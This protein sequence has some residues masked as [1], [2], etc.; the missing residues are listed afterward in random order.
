[1]LY[2]MMGLIVGVV[3]LG[4]AWLSRARG[5]RLTWYEWLFAGA[6]I[7]LAVLAVQNF[8]G[9]LQEFEPG[10]ALLLLGLFSLPALALALIDWFLVSR[11]RKGTAAAMP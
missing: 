4:L 6:A 5:V 1:M 3:V 11:H 10:A 2:F 9:S 8:D 7:I